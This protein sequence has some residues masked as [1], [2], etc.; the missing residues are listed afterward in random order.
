VGDIH[1]WSDHG[2]WLAPLSP[3]SVH[4]TIMGRGGRGVP[5]RP[6]HRGSQRARVEPLM[7][8][9]PCLVSKQKFGSLRS[10][11]IEQMRFKQRLKV[12]QSLED[13]AKRSVVSDR[14]AV[15]KPLLLVYL[16]YLCIYLSALFNH[17]C[18]EAVL[19]S[20]LVLLL[21]SIPMKMQMLEF[22]FYFHIE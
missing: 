2:C 1:L 21:H 5:R 20:L 12:I 13:T 17:Y 22:Y 8:R 4:L 11:V 9:S 16:I 10:D 14:L 3:P 6:V 7:N 18:V 15:W 19:N